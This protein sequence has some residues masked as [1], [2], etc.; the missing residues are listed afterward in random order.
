IT[1]LL[2]ARAQDGSDRET[3][4]SAIRALGRSPDPN[5]A[6]A[7]V[8][9]KILADAGLQYPA[10]LALARS[11]APNATQLC[12]AVAAGNLRTLGVR[13]Y[14]VRALLRGERN[15]Q[16]DGVIAQLMGA[17]EPRDRALAVFSRISLGQASAED[18]IDD[19][20]PRIR[21]AAAM[22]TLAKP[23]RDMQRLLLSRMAKETDDVTRQVFA[24]GLLSGDPDASI[25][26]TALVDRAE[27]GGA[28]A[29]LSAYALARRAANS[30]AA[31]AAA[32]GDPLARQGGLLLGSTDAVPRAHAAPGVPPPP[33]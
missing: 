23:T 4:L 17:K 33:P 18:F 31:G 2:A 11:P 30:F 13:A 21:R 1:K 9:T 22:A 5:A 6:T 32:P 15:D 7:L 27:S 26:T 28:D 29:A 25:T 24:I 19:K 10:M 14:V 3:R 20:E 8:S 12:A 16:A